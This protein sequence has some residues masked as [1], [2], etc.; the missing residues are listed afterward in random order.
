MLVQ[1]AAVL[2]NTPESG[3]DA[4]FSLQLY[5]CLFV[6][7]KSYDTAMNGPTQAQGVA[8]ENLVTLAE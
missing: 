1:V 6:Q 7:N 8:L 3:I 5:S 2:R 4:K